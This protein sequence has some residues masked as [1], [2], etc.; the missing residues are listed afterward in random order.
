[1]ATQVTKPSK[2][3]GGGYLVHFASEFIQFVS[4]DLL[5]LLSGQVKRTVQYKVF[6]PLLTCLKH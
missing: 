1:M 2:I 4:L 5:V 6:L 3:K